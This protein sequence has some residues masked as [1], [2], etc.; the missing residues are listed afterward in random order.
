M[1]ATTLQ[2]HDAAKEN[3]PCGGFYLVVPMC[4]AHPIIA[5]WNGCGWRPDTG[6]DVEF[7]AALPTAERIRQK[8]IDKE[9]KK[10]G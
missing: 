8:F 6:F 7:W 1:T 5:N 3:P 2:W 10:N 9:L 4:Y